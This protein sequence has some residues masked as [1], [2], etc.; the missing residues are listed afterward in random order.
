MQSSLEA[1]RSAKV[2]EFPDMAKLDYFGVCPKCFRNDGYLNIERD[3]WYHC[4]THKLKWWIGSN[5]FSCWQL[6]DESTWRA[7]AE[8][9]AGYTEVKEFNP[10]DADVSLK[11]N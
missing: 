8:L 2:I 9:L 10:R 6:E 4:R 1:R 11:S 3:H 5:L 7:N